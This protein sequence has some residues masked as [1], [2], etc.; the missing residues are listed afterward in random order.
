MKCPDQK[1]LQGFFYRI[2]ESKSSIAKTNLT[3]GF[4]YLFIFVSKLHWAHT[5]N[6]SFPGVGIH[7]AR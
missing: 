4:I 1:C 5:N 3:I 6:F 7:Y 2:L